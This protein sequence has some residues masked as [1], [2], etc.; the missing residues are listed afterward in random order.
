MI[1][2][3]LEDF[4]KEFSA[5]LRT[6]MPCRDGTFT[7]VTEWDYSPLTE[8]LVSNTWGSG[9]EKLSTYQRQYWL[10]LWSVLQQELPLTAR[11]LGLWQFNHLAQKFLLAVP[12]RDPDIS[13][14]THGFEEF[15]A[16]HVLQLSQIVPLYPKALPADA[17]QQAVL[18]DLAWQKV[19]QAP[20]TPVWQ[21]KDLTPET[22]MSLKLRLGT[23]AHLLHEEWPL[24]ELRSTVMQDNAETAVKLPARLPEPQHWVLYRL[25]TAIVQQRLTAEQAS[26]YGQL[27]QSYPLGEVLAAWEARTDAP[28]HLP[29]LIMNWLR[30]SLEMGLW[31][32]AEPNYAIS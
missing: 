15:V 31:E 28:A 8:N 7:A 29:T 24:M 19:F 27:H 25:R 9:R 12:P 11:L 10:R 32:T 1:P 17:L 14:L 2:S 3:W 21:P 18:V 5:C 26:F 22:L 13:R 4:Q 20:E 23:H 6:P 16:T 30:S